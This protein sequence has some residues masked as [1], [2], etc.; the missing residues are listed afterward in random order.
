MASLSEDMEKAGFKPNLMA[1]MA[2]AGYKAPTPQNEMQ[3]TP[4]VQGIKKEGTD[5][6][7]EAGGFAGDL[8]NRFSQAK[9]ALGE[10]G[11]SI[12]APEAGLRIAG[13]V[14]GAGNDL[15]SR[16]M[17]LVGKTA[18]NVTGGAIGSVLEALAK[19]P[20]GVAA[21]SALKSG[22]DK[23]EEFKTTYPRVAA[24]V[25]PLLEGGNLALNAT[26]VGEGVNAGIKGAKMLGGG[27][28]KAAEPVIKAGG[29]AYDFTANIPKALIESRR[30]GAIDSLEQFYNTT[31]GRTT[32]GSK[33]LYQGQLATDAKNAAGTEGENAP[34]ILAENGIVP[35]QEGNQL[36]TL[37]QAAKFRQDTLQLR[38]VNRDAI[39]QVVNAVPRTKM[40]D[41]EK[42]ALT[43]ARSEQNV[44]SGKAAPLERQIK[45]AFN[46]YRIDYGNEIPLDKVDDIKSARWSNKRNF[47]D[48][49]GKDVDYLIGKAA[50]KTVE[51]TATSA[52]FDDVA[53]LNRHIGDRLEAAKFLEGLDKKRVGVG[54]LTRIAV[55]GAASTAGKTIHGKILYAMGGDAAMSI[56]TSNSIAGPVKR[57]VLQNLEKKNPEAYKE[58]VKWL[59]EQKILRETRP[60]LPA[61]T[62]GQ[63]YINQGR[64]IPVAP[65]GFNGDSISNDVTAS[66]RP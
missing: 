59:E 38:Q 58:A 8:Q 37:E 19:T 48:D 10:S 65:K 31:A 27:V 22:G 17:S 63:S 14:L 29:K 33:K 46:Q 13:S 56:L 35:K 39:K 16:G 20:I 40:D 25:E 26:G 57:L 55:M 15:L 32:T 42:Q 23:W 4:L 43:L 30:P 36:A 53:Q 1:D 6:A 50:Q 11:K 7:D 21:I 44:A 45:K 51:D 41:L 3:N 34:R 54:G 5:I 12:T 2:G 66:T 28:M 52:G 47:T 61:P 9:T 64:P 49:L 18:N 24:D 62:P 60:K